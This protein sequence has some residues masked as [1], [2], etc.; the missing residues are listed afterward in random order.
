MGQLGSWQPS[1]TIRHD[2]GGLRHTA[3]GLFYGLYPKQLRYFRPRLVDGSMNRIQ[4]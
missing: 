4:H 1:A 2:S 3:S